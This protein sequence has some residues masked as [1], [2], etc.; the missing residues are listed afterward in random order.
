MTTD[1]YCIR[2]LRVDSDESSKRRSLRNRDAKDLEKGGL[3]G[4]FHYRNWTGKFSTLKVVLLLIVL[5]TVYTLY[6]SPAV[7]IADHPSNNNS[8]YLVFPAHLCL[9]SV[10]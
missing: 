2:L 3:H 7:H 5:G 4:S 6:R 8:R 1:P 10:D 9:F